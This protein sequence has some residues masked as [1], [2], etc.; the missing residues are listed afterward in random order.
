MEINLEASAR[1]AA[2]A[3]EDLD[4]LADW[5]TAARISGLHVTGKRAEVR[6]GDMGAGLVEALTLSLG[7]ATAF[8]ELVKAVHAWLESRRARPVTEVE[9]ELASG[10][11][12]VIKAGLPVDALVREARAALA[13]ER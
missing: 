4:D 7:V 10:A 8:V 6:S 11:R 1:L 2:G 9:L 12:I 13:T 5:L 3:S